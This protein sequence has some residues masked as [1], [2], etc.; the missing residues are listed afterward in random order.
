MIEIT[1]AWLEKL[2]AVP[3]ISCKSTFMSNVSQNAKE[4][5]FIYS[6]KHP[7]QCPNS[8]KGA[9]SAFTAP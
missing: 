5:F 8:G 7:N 2:Q 9:R 4:R 6:R 1:D 3:F